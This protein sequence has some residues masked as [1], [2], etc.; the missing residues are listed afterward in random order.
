MLKP[1]S[2]CPPVLVTATEA[3]AGSPLPAVALNVTLVGASPIA[4]GGG[5]TVNVTLTVCGELDA[6]L[7]VTLTVALYVP[8][9]SEPVVACNVIVDGAVVELSDAFNQPVG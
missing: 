5:A 7:D 9:A 4:A 2:G 1:V 6:T 8:A 3:A